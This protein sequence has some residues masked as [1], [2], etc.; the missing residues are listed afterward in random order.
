MTVGELLQIIETRDMRISAKFSDGSSL[1]D[2]YEISISVK[3][4][5]RF[6]QAKVERI[7]IS[8]YNQMFIRATGEETRDAV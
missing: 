8:P 5:G 7:G 3:G 1:G 6:S 4:H 2:H